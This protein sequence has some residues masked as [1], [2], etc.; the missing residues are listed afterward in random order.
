MNGSQLTVDFFQIIWKKNKKKNKNSAM[1][2]K[3]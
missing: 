2:K 3:I 1:D